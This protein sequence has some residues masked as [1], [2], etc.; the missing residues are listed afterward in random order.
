M[1]VPSHHLP[2]FVLALSGFKATNTGAWLLS[3][4]SC[5]QINKP[6][7]AAGVYVP[8]AAER[9]NVVYAWMQQLMQ[10]RQRQGGLCKDAPIGSRAW[11]MWSEGYLAFEQCRWAEVHTRP[12]HAG[13]LVSISV[14]GCV[15][16]ACLLIQGLPLQMWSEATMPLS[17]A[18]ALSAH[19]CP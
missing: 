4:S 15:S 5:R 6:P 9:V 17:S 18:G 16:N 12:L 2:G 7:C 11:Q 10:E 1:L 8:G 3:V 14:G 19:A 13:Q